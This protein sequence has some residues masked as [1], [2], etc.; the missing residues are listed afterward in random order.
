MIQAM[1]T[2]EDAAHQLVGILADE[3][4]DHLFINPGTDTAPVQEAL[5]AARVSGR[6]SPRSVLCV[7]EHVALSSA[8]AH[9]MLSG[10]PQA[11][12]VHVDAGTLNLGGA[13]HN[14]Q[15]NRTPVVVMAGRAPYT[16]AAEVPGHRDNRIHW[17]QEQL[18]QAA[19]MRAYGR[20]TM[21]VPRGRELG[22]VLRR[23]FQV[24]QIPPGA[25]CYV[26][27][28]REALM[29]PAGPTTPRLCPPLPPGPDPAGLA[30]LAARLASARHPVL[31]TG[32]TGAA[33]EAVTHLVRLAELLGAPVLDHRDRANFP[34]GH[35]LYAGMAEELLG[36]SDVVLLLD[37]DVPWIPAQAGP[38][39]GAAVLQIDLDCAKPTM[40]LW[41]FP[42]QL[43][44]TADTRTALPAL[45]E[46]LE[47]TASPE[48]RRRW[49]ER[50]GEVQEELDAIR[51]GWRRRATSDAPTDAADAVLAA[52]EAALPPDAVVLEEAVT[53]RPAAVRQLLRA[54]G[55]LFSSGAPSLGWAVAAAMGAKLARP[56][57]PV[58]ALC[59]DGAF[60]FSVPSAALWS[61]QRAGTPFVVVVLNNG[62]YLASRR[63]VETLYPEG[64]STRTA[65]FPET[66][67][68]PPLDLPLL[69]R[70]CGGQ[71]QVVEGPA[72]LA[73]AVRWALEVTAGG[74]CAVLDVRLPRP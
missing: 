52:L 40:P 48:A 44:L 13:I 60:R 14:A 68:W 71:G 63:P 2:T 61:A 26:M 37:V 23:A 42:V 55:R 54:P 19:T 47:R 20:W 18:D 59:G 29:E 17:P 69:A 38:P 74:E 49:Q 41:T 73:A 24:A 57:A 67:L 45:L 1:T 50:A 5:A 31:V 6:A 66:D 32:R 28:P 62:A 16:S 33:T 8:I 7:H 15:R 46:I 53:S 72:D 11:V 36:R 51:A 21:E 34:A 22:P 27:L 39:P 25:L 56:G 9:H 12:M 30:D 64:V 65:D 43:A 10:R 58:V 35:P 3:G 4:V 70:A